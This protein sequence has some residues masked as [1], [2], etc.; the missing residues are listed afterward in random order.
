MAAAQPQFESPLPAP[1]SLETLAY[2]DLLH[3]HSCVTTKSAD[4]YREY[5]LTEQQFHVLRLLECAAPCGL[6]CLEV[7]RQLPTPAPDITRLIE[8]MRRAGLVSRQRLEQDRRVVRI[9]LTPRG[10]QL[11]ARLRPRVAAFHRERLAHLS[12]DELDLL[13]HLLRK[14]RGEIC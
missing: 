14:A 11:H 5:G 9:E 7:A 6:P 10:R 4:L 13:G 3:T 2:R 12:A 8:R 1:E